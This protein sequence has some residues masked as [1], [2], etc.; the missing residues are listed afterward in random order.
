MNVQLNSSDI[1]IILN[2]PH[3]SLKVRDYLGSVVAESKPTQTLIRMA[4]GQ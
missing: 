3:L 4:A 1:G 2:T